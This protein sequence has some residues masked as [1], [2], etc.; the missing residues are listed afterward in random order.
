MFPQW[1]LV[2]FPSV[3]DLHATSIRD[4]YFNKKWNDEESPEDVFTE[5]CKDSLNEG[6]F[7]FMVDWRETETYE[8]LSGEY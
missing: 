7:Q 8:Y 1:E 2:E 3:K 6:I 4:Y 5:M